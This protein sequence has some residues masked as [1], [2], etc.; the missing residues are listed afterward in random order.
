MGLGGT[1]FQR[2]GSACPDGGT[3]WVPCSGPPWTTYRDLSTHHQSQGHPYCASQWAQEGLG[4]AALAAEAV[5]PSLGLC[6]DRVLHAECERQEP[7]GV[8]GQMGP[9]GP[10]GAKPLRDAP[11]SAQAK[12]WRWGVWFWEPWGVC[13]AVWAK[14]DHECS[15]HPR[16]H[17]TLPAPCSEAPC[18][19]EGAEGSRTWREECL[20]LLLMA[21]R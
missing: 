19:A 8:S 20:V 10:G 18:G 7:P 17:P 2:A 5:W 14:P 1:C 4:T 11:L 21:P 15:P 13:P 3:W 16:G 12:C 6:D 9:H